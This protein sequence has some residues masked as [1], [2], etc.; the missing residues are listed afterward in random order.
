MLWHEVWTTVQHE[1]SDLPDAAQV[2]R[3]LLRLLV[4]VLLGGL[5]GYEREKMKARPASGR[6]C[7]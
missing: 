3:V 7:W 6:I 2:T 4:A 1:F 5:L